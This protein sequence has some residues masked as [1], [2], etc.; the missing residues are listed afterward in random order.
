MDVEDVFSSRLRI[1][2]LK[3]LFQMSELNV[4]E[5]ARR[6]NVNYSTTIEHLKI[7]E[8]EGIVCHKIF[9]RIR[10]YRLNEKSPKTRAL[11]NLLDVW[12]HAN[13]P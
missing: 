9:G 8:D 5:I 7:L 1:K 12:E 6:L 3:I 11:Q 4:S 2:I 10:L 13:K